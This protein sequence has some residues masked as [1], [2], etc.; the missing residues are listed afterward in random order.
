MDGLGKVQ[1]KH[2]FP[3]NSRRSFSMKHIFHVSLLLII[4]FSFAAC[5]SNKLSSQHVEPSQP[6]P[7]AQKAAS[8]GGNQQEQPAVTPEP[9]QTKENDGEKTVYDLFV[10]ET[11]K[12]LSYNGYTITKT[13]KKVWVKEERKDAPITVPYSILK[14]KGKTIK[15]F[16]DENFS[17]TIPD[18]GM[19]N[20]L[21]KQEKQLIVAQSQPRNARFWI[22]GLYPQYQVLF[23]TDDWGNSRQE[24]WIEDLDKDGIYEIKIVNFDFLYAAKFM[25]LLT[26]PQPLI[27]FKYNRQR[28]RYLPANHIFQHHGSENVDED[29]KSLKLTTDN[30]TPA[31]EEVYLQERAEILLAYIFTG[32]EKRGWEFFDKSYLLPDREEMKAAIKSVLREQAVYR[33]IYRKQT[34]NR[35]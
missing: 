15:K 29:I 30:L 11:Q 26:T 8:D 20:L 3:Y 25:R 19:F 9:E 23:D 6:T 10:P 1:T 4:A 13:S 31:D 7:V 35:A 34:K 22:I 18:F 32:R 5:Q 17:L 16:A 14:R 28:N 33:F 2:P 21:G 12:S 24:A 27:I